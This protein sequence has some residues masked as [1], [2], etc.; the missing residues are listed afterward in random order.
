MTQVR[1]ELRRRNYSISTE[2]IYIYWLRQYFYFHQLKHPAGLTGDDVTRFLNHLA[3]NKRVSASAQSQALNA[4]AFLYKQ[5]LQVDLGS[6]DDLKRPKRFEYL[7][8][9]LSADEVKAILGCMAGKTGLA[10]SLLYG[11]GMRINECVTLRVQDIDL[12]NGSICIRNTKGRK[13]RVTLL[14][15]KLVSPLTQHLVWRKHLHVSD[16]SK[17]WGYVDLP[18]ALN[19]KYPKAETQFE[20]QYVF[21]SSTV[22][23]DRDRPNVVRRWYMSK[24]TLSK[25]LKRAVNQCNITKRVTAHTLRHSFATHLL[26][27]GTDIRTIQQLMGHK[28]LKTTMIYT[29][30]AAEHCKN[31]KSPFDRL[32]D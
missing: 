11:T 7:P 18:N 10:A 20:W 1:H 24:S 19:R 6:L 23:K 28:D 12:S 32:F 9:V 21:P 17:G 22:N 27:S 25:S 2:R 29:H 13:S 16:L 8:T 26:Q 31:T 15:E 3:V 14:P 30:I 4:L 5:I